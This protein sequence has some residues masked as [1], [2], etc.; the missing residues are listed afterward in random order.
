ML[1]GLMEDW[2]ISVIDYAIMTHHNPKGEYSGDNVGNC[3]CNCLWQGRADPRLP[4][5]T[6][7]LY[8]CRGHRKTLLP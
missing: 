3:G 5:N 1:A 7:V 8:H 2:S 6:P 4:I